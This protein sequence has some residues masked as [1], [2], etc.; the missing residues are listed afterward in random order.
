MS[1]MIRPVLLATVLLLTACRAEQVKVTVV[2]L[3]AAS[4]LK[5]A[6]AV[7]C[8]QAAVHGKVVLVNCPLKAQPVVKKV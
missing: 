1:T 4:V 7:Q 6:A 3:F 5:K 8:T 2:R